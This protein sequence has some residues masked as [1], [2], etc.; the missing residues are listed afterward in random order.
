MIVI[1]GSNGLWPT[2]HLA[3]TILSIMLSHNDN[4]VGVRRR[5]GEN[6][7][8][9]MTE[10]IAVRI[11]RKL[12]M[13]TYDYVSMATGSKAGFVRDN[14]MVKGANHVYAFFAPGEEMK[15][16]TGHVVEAALRGG[17]PVTAYHLDG[18]GDLVEFGS[19]EETSA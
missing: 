15:G 16:G 1:V 10:E 4:I 17:V 14:E 5:H 6:K 13:N 9:S 11:A 19:F 3:S 8:V 7:P 18:R 2:P 12:S